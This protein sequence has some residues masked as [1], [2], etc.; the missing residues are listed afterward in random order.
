M[1]LVHVILIIAAIVRSKT[2]STSTCLLCG[3]S[4]QRAASATLDLV[5][6]FCLDGLGLCGLTVICKQTLHIDLCDVNT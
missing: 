6:K 4:V 5:S 2:T 1:L 3:P